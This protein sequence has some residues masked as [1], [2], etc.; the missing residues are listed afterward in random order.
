MD[1][2]FFIYE[3]QPSF[4]DQLLLFDVLGVE[5]PRVAFLY[6]PFLGFNSS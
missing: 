6:F 3:Q 4:L 5:T 1:E 2:E